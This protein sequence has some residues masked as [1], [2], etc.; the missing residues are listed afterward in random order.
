MKIAFKIFSILTIIYFPCFHN[1][2]C[3]SLFPLF[4]VIYFLKI[5]SKLIYDI[6]N[7]YMGM[8]GVIVYVVMFKQD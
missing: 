2:G 1:A 8:L 6:S 7:I 4:L 5:L 3:F